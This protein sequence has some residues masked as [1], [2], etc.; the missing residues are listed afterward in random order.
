MRR[1]VLLTV[2]ICVTFV[3]GQPAWGEDGAEPM[4]FKVAYLEFPPY[5]FTNTDGDPDGFL[6]KKADDIFR[7]AG[8]EPQYESQPAKHV[9]MQMRGLIPLCSIGW[10]KTPKRESFAKFSKPMYQNE[11]LHVLY[12]KENSHLFMNRN[13]LSEVLQDK[14][15][16]M[17]RVGGYSY[18]PVVDHL[19]KK[20]EPSVLNI[21]GEQPQLIRMLAAGHFTY[22]LA[23]P[24]EIETLIGKNYLSPELFQ[25][26]QLSDLPA[27]NHR[28]LMFSR[29]VPDEVV[30]RINCVIEDGVE[31]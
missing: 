2:V 21:A 29:G 13:S 4:P 20:Y 15:L 22:M 18:G 1:I 30:I 5:Y 7:L 6:L 25:S 12:L 17:G 31:R 23:A 14:S 27:G 28:Y 10:F 11:P 26:K 8:L 16:V 24:E 3:L 19:F 9:L